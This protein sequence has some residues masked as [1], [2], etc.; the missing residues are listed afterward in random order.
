ARRSASKETNGVGMFLKKL[1]VVGCFFFALG[2][3]A[4][5]DDKPPVGPSPTP[6]SG[7]PDAGSNPEDSGPDVPPGD[8]R[9]CETST[10]AEGTFNLSPGGLDYGY[11]VHLPP[12]YDGTKRTPLLLN[13]HGRG[14]AANEQQL[15]TGTD[16]VANDEGFIVVY[17]NSPDKSWGA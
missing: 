3:A 14:S 8:T 1:H 2:F 9:P 16:L 7:P 5:S 13:W 11:I 6:D 4:C 12:S 10:I 15:L 17:P